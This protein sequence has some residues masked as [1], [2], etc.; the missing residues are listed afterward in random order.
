ML[1]SITEG[2][3]KPLKYPLMFQMSEVLIVNKIDLVP[4]LDVSLEKIR[5]DAKS[6]NPKLEI[7]EVSCKTGEGLDAWYG[8]LEERRDSQSLH[9][10][11]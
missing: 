11:L 9:G 3:D 2:D 10:A 6:L 4:H 5:G 8:W 1:L 7:F